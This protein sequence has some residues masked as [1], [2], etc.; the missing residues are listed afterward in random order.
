MYFKYA[1]ASALKSW[2]AGENRTSV[3]T[4]I[5]KLFYMFSFHLF[6]DAQPTETAMYT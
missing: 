6:F 4:R 2:K 3:K 1:Q 5:T